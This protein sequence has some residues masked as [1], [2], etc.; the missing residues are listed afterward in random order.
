MN[1]DMYLHFSMRTTFYEEA[2]ANGWVPTKPLPLN[3]TVLRQYWRSLF[4]LRGQQEGI[5][6]GL[7]LQTWLHLV[8]HTALESLPIP[9]QGAVQSASREGADRA[10]SGHLK[11]I[12][13]GELFKV[14][15]Q[16]KNSALIE[17]LSNKIFSSSLFEPDAMKERDPERK[18]TNKLP[19]RKRSIALKMKKKYSTLYGAI[20]SVKAV[21]Y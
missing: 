21:S 12:R 8:G 6:W 13:R 5:G 20:P 19:L 18:L 17:K 2:F 9:D 16:K 4:L 3:L 1:Y 10:R 7:K 15:I 11:A 14:Q